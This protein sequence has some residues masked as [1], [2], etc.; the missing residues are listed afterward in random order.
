MYVFVRALVRNLFC[1]GAELCFLCFIAEMCNRV[2]YEARKSGGETL[3][4]LQN[5]YGSRSTTKLQC[6]N[7][8][9]ILK[10]ETKGLLMTLEVRDEAL[11]LQI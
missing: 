10:T 5:V 2:L 6:F 4:M 7:G 1:S 9:S 3:K 11:L 8:G